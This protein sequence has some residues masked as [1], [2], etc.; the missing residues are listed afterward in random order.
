MKDEI[1][2]HL[3]DIREADQLSAVRQWCR[4]QILLDNKAKKLYI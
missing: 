3:H 4:R 2:K 1:L